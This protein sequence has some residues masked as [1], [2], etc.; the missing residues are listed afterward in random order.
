MFIRGLDV[1]PQIHIN[2]IFLHMTINANLWY[3][4]SNT[5][6][7]VLLSKLLVYVYCLW[8][9]RRMRCNISQSLSPS[10]C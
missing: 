8:M 1:N 3:R 6:G 9:G 7:S 5:G 10:D 4:E 2:M